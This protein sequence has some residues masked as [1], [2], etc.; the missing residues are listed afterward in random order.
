VA[1]GAPGFLVVDGAQFQFRLQAP[2]HRLDLGQGHAGPPHPLG[3]PV[4]D[5][6]VQAVHAGMLGHVPSTGSQC[7]ELP[8]SLSGSW[9]PQ[10]IHVPV[11]GLREGS[12]GPGR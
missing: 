5:I 12:A 2:E 9:P 7:Q 8:T 6:A 3:I 4:E 10:E 1:L 11:S